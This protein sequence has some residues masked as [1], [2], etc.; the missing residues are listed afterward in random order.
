MKAVLGFKG[1]RLKW[2]E[3]VKIV[4]NNKSNIWNELEPLLV[5][6][7]EKNKKKVNNPVNNF[8]NLKSKDIV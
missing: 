7:I 5:N 4:K 6:Y 3:F 8:T 1:N 2:R